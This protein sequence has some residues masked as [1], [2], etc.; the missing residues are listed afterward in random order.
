LFSVSS[1]KQA[2]IRLARR[3][4][5]ISALGNADGEI[6]FRV[7]QTTMRLTDPFQVGL[8]AVGW[9]DRTIYY[10]AYPNGTAIRFDIFQLWA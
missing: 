1:S 2:F 6:W 8:H 5:Q 9:I 7:G 3:G 10:G 4:D